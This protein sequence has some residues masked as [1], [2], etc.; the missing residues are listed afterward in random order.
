MTV[1][2]KTRNS[3]DPDVIE[4]AYNVRVV[5]LLETERTV[6]AR[7]EIFHSL[8]GKDSHGYCRTYGG[9]VP[10]SAVYNSRSSSQATGPSLA[11]IEQQV[12]KIKTH[13]LEYME[14]R[15]SY[16]SRQVHD[17]SSGHRACTE[18]VGDGLSPL[19]QTH[20]TTPPPIQRLNEQVIGVYLLNSGIPKEDVGEGLLITT[21]PMSEMD[22]KPLGEGYCKVL[23]EKANKPTANLERPR[24][25]LLTVGDA[26]GRYVAWRYSDVIEKEMGD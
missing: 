4:A 1:F 23:V 14:S 12:D 5:A 3:D 17:A 9:G 19:E 11:E 26:V 21:D 22:G 13:M 24:L 8:I 18:S 20:T 25:N 6:E 2:T 7:D 10:R 16:A 15:G